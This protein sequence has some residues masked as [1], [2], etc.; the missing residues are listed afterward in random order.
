MIGSPST[1]V[2]PSLRRTPSTSYII[3]RGSKLRQ[4]AV[5][6]CSFKSPPPQSEQFTC[7]ICITDR[8]MHEPNVTKLSCGHMFCMTC[9]LQNLHHSNTCPHCRAPI[10]QNVRHKNKLRVEDGLDIIQNNLEILHIDEALQTALTMSPP[11]AA[12]NVIHNIILELSFYNIYEAL[13]HIEGHNQMDTEWHEEM[14]SIQE[15]FR[16]FYLDHPQTQASITTE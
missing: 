2:T 12:I 16:S 13:A 8:H 11:T 7:T 14:N 15:Y 9:L 5:D 1:P 3:R 10:E 6:N 4:Q